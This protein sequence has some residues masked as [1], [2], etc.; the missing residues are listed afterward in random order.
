MPAT[1]RQ[2]QWFAENA[3][4][5]RE[6]RKEYY[7][8]PE[9]KARIKKW[10]ADNRERLLAGKKRYHE[11]HKDEDNARS[12]AYRAE[13]KEETREMILNWRKNNSELWKYHHDKSQKKYIANNNIVARAH[14]T[15]FR[16]IQRGELVAQ[17]CEVCGGKKTEAHHDDYNK[18]L[19]VRWLCK[20]CHTEWHK[21]N[22]PIKRKE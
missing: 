11:A 8:R 2:K 17:A 1:E 6:Y 15:V 3:E 16:A 7:S 19:E 18:P 14:G 5:L 10:R 13:H 4:R 20:K 21:H 9:V 12:K 22:K